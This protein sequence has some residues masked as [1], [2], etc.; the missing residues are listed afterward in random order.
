VK[1]IA[2]LACVLGALGAASCGDK[3]TCAGVGLVRVVPTDTTIG[4]QASFVARYQEGGTCGDLTDARYNDV[5]VTWRTLDSTIIVLDSV[6]GKVT[7]R[8]VGDA[9]V[10]TSRGLNLL[11]RVR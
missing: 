6:A 3:I 5:P 9:H 1:R 10:T 7:G 2:I 4:V 8:A 11:V